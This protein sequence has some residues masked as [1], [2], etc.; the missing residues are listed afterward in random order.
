MTRKN[1]KNNI[2]RINSLDKR[3]FTRGAAPAATDYTKRD[4][5]GTPVLSDQDVEFSKE[6]VEENEK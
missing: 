2:N 1:K 4:R 3:I 6:F 5:R